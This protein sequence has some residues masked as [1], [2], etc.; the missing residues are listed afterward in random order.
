MRFLYKVCTVLSISLLLGAV[1]AVFP[2][3][4]SAQTSP[5][6]TEKRIWV[7]S[8]YAHINQVDNTY[9]L[10]MGIVLNAECHWSDGQVT[11]GPENGATVTFTYAGIQGQA[12]T[13]N[14]GS[15]SVTLN[16]PNP[17]SGFWDVSVSDNSNNHNLSYSAT[18]TVSVP[19]SANTPTATPAATTTP[20]TPL[21]TQETPIPTVSSAPTAS[22]TAGGGFVLVPGFEALYAV[23]G[24]LAVAYLVMRRR[25]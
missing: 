21:P 9:S 20:T 8:E 10:M 7:T 11:S 1:I 14:A 19:Q 5:T 24:L 23:A 17:T 15:A 12:V 16:I 18:Y 4:T 25:K 22:A 6:C 2:T 13:D 3:V